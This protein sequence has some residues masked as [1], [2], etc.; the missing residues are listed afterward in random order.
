MTEFISFFGVFAPGLCVAIFLV[1]SLLAVLRLE[2]LSKQGIE[3]SVLG[4]IFMPFFSGVGNIAFAVVLALNLGDGNDILTNCLFHNMTNMTLLIGVPMLIWSMAYLPNH[5]AWRE[6][7]EFKIGRL[8]TELNLVAMFFFAL[9]LWLLAMDGEL[10]KADGWILILLFV[11]WH[12]FHIYD[13]K[14]TNLLKRKAYPRTLWL[15]IVILLLCSWAI[16]ISIDYLVAWFQAL[17]P[18]VMPPRMLGWFSGVLMVLPNALL[19]IYYGSHRRMDIVYA[20]QVGDAH[21]CIPFCVGLF[22][23]MRP[24]QV[25]EFLL[26]SLFILMGLFLSHLIFMMM[27]PKFSRVF[28]ALFIAVFFVFIW[29][30]L[31]T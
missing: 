19:A 2:N 15:D 7:C 12:C 24:F 10:S 9:F 14:K 16:Y 22:V 23:V 6:V 17:D 26:Q 18:N 8:S 11:F 29:L 28:A 3:G 4:T 25:G 21:V 13:V 1:A 5:K 20:S 27:I 31:F 30:G